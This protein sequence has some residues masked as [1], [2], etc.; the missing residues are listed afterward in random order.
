VISKAHKNYFRTNTTKGVI[1]ESGNNET[2]S[3]ASN[4]MALKRLPVEGASKSQRGGG[5]NCEHYDEN[6]VVL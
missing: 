1:P 3:C 2:T 5:G 4:A 6:G